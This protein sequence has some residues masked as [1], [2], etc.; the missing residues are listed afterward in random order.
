MAETKINESIL[1]DEIKEHLK[2][3]RI[4]H[5]E[6]LPGMEVL[7]DT[8]IQDGV[9][10][11]MEAYD[12][13]KYTAADVQRALAKESCTPE[14]FAALLSPAAMP[15]LEEIAQRA[16]KETKSILEIP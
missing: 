15:F 3:N 14:D 9:L 12:Y 1:N 8:R 7:E 16:R 6:H 13:E 10:S 2:E 5:M 11:A 4:N